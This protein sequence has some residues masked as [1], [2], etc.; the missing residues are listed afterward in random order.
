MSHKSSLISTFSF[1]CLIKFSNIFFLNLQRMLPLEEKQRECLWQ[2][3]IHWKVCYHSILALS[4]CA[5][6]H[7]LT[8]W[9]YKRSPCEHS[10]QCVQASTSLSNSWLRIACWP[11]ETAGIALVINCFLQHIFGESYLSGIVLINFL[12]YC[13]IKGTLK[14]MCICNWR[15]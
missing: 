2:T 7:V 13:L 1:L 12:F 8:C 15:F 14:T 6:G 4:L 3:E 9:N 10:C 5:G 11:P